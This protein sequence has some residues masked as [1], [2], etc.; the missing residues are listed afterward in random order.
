MSRLVELSGHPGPMFPS[1]SMTP[2]MLMEPLILETERYS[3]PPVHRSCS[4]CHSYPIVKGGRGGEHGFLKGVFIHRRMFGHR[5]FFLGISPIKLLCPPT[6]YLS[7]LNPTSEMRFP[8]FIGRL[9]MEVMITSGLHLKL[10]LKYRPKQWSDVGKLNNK[11][12]ITPNSWSFLLVC[13][14]FEYAIKCLWYFASIK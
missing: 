6:N 3:E 5:I 14:D 2:N 12:H 8:L 13:I 1:R 10:W 4:P 11:Q 7:L 9:Y